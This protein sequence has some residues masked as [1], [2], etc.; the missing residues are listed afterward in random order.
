MDKTY[1]YELNGCSWRSEADP[2]DFDEF[3]KVFN[4]AYMANLAYDKARGN[5]VIANP[6]SVVRFKAD[7]PLSETDS[8]AFYDGA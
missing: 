1:L 6:D 4:G 8:N 2:F 3:R 7:A 5:T